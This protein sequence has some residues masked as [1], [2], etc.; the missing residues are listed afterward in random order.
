MDCVPSAKDH[1]RTFLLIQRLRNA[2]GRAEA[3][4]GQ[5]GVPDE[6]VVFADQHVGVAVAVQ[7]DEFQV[8]VAHVAVE[9]RGERAE[10]LPAFVVV[11]F[12]EAGHGAVQHHQI[13]LA[14]AGEVHELRLPAGQGEVGFG[15]N[16]FQRREFDR[17]AR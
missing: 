16:P 15:G 17:L 4:L 10:G 12:V 13:G 8:G 1:A 14:V 11:V 3:L 6:G 9:A 5:R 2:A 7:I